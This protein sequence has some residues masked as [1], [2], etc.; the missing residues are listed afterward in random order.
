[1]ISTSAFTKSVVADH[2]GINSI[3]SLSPERV[4]SCLKHI[5]FSDSFS[6]HD[7]IDIDLHNEMHGVS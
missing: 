1:M 5:L 3:L 2:D 6:E 4:S 7:S